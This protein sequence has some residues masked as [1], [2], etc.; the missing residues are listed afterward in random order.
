MW[1]YHDKKMQEL[2][3]L[4]NR[5]SKQTQNQLQEIF[6]SIDFDFSNLYSIVDNKKKNRINTYIEE[7]KDKGLLTGYFG[8]LAN[9]IYKRTRVKNSEIL[10]L[11][12]Y[13]AYVEEQ[14]KLNESELKI[15]KSDV[16]HYYQQGQD[17]VNKSLNQKKIV[18]VIP[19]AIFLAMLDMPNAKG[20]VY[21]DYIQSIL[22]FNAEQLYRQVVIDIQQQKQLKIDSDIYQNI[23]KRQQNQKLNINGDKIS[24]DVDL[25]LIGL[26][27]RAKSEGIYSLDQKAKVKFISV[28]DNNTTKMCRSLEGQIFNVHDWN[29]F[30]RYSETNG[31][32][33]KYKCYGLIPGLNLPPI[34][35]YFHWCRSTIAY[36]LGFSREDLLNA[37][38]L[39]DDEYG[40]LK[41]YISSESYKIN[42]SLYNNKSLTTQQSKLKENL[43]QA[44]RHMP[45]YKGIVKRSVRVETPEQ[46]SKILSVFDNDTRIGAWESYISSSKNVYDNSFNLQFTIKSKTGRDLSLLNDEGGR[47]SVICPQY[48]IPTN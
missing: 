4:Y 33:T 11:L 12:I 26:N 27:N 39:N 46:L 41:R 20:Y 1:Q 9:N 37:K 8:V 17:E 3:A 22:R 48:T 18:S 43:D 45:I 34:D 40:A 21:N 10:E 16:G 42:S 44:L 29:E 28:E 14:A 36:N 47:R 2:K 5:I 7:W 6:D 35:D 13:G 25:T 30:E 32:T 15:F 23:I 19:D 38:H 31:R 24:G